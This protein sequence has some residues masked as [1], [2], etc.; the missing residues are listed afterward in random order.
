MGKFMVGKNISSP[1]WAKSFN[2]LMAGVISVVIA[3]SLFF[4]ANTVMI[5]KKLK[6]VE[7]APTPYAMVQAAKYVGQK[8][9]TD[10]MSKPPEGVTADSWHVGHDTSI[11]TLP[12]SYY[13]QP[14]PP[15]MLSYATARS[16]N[17]TVKTMIFGAG[18]AKM[19]YDKLVNN[20]TDNTNL[21]DPA[22]TPKDHITVNNVS[23][24]TRG[25]VI[26]SVI[27]DDANL[28]K[29]VTTDYLVKLDEMLQQ[30]GCVDL[31]EN[32]DDASRSFYY[33]K[34]SYSGLQKTQ[35]VAVNT[36]IITPSVPQALLDS[37]MRAS[38]M[39]VDPAEQVTISQPE[40]PLPANFPSDMPKKPVIPTFTVQPSTPSNSQTV[41]VQAADYYG[42]GCGWA[43]TGQVKPYY[44]VQAL[45]QN[46]NITITNA[47]NQLSNNIMA[48]NKSVIDY[49]LKT[50]IDSSFIADWESYTDNVNQTVQKWKDL[51]TKRD[52]F[53]TTWLEYV[54]KA[55]KFKTV[56]ANMFNN[57]E[58]S[59]IKGINSE[60][61]KAWQKN[62]VDCVATKLSIKPSDAEKL[63]YDKVKDSNPL[64]AMACE[65]TIPKPNLPPTASSK[66]LADNLLK[67][68]KPV[69]PT[70]PDGMT[71]PD[72]WPA[73]PLK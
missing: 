10:F 42:P 13:Q 60:I 27:S 28:L 18:Q 9:L 63:D 43:W 67:G 11:S 46:E 26:V 12:A 32:S 56:T 39:F 51:N 40:S 21:F 44:N 41:L 1:R 50:M 69:K 68:Y 71:I 23:L 57:G 54:D 3:V 38:R 29:T 25:D 24:M 45:K 14:A 35:K 33:N 48:Y 62:I 53:K 31:N 34:Q 8:F 5:I 52:S 47:K 36:K 37:H 59:D 16:K 61:L 66:E 55:Q 22:N 70:L 15:S 6:T 20:L 2:C 72:S 4:I 17:L 64:T 7:H 49:S 30:S 19:F 65:K 73:D 58:L